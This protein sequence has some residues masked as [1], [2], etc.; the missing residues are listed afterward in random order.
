MLA[1][2]AATPGTLPL[3]VPAYQTSPPSYVLKRS[4]CSRLPPSAAIG[5]PLASAFA[6]VV[7]SGSTP[8]S[9]WNPPRW[10]RKPVMTSSKISSGAVAV[11]QRAQ[12]L[13]EARP[14]SDARG[15]VDDRLGDHR[16]HLTRLVREGAARRSRGR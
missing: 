3:Y 8:E 9:A 14:G 10:W 5:K 2:A 4:M 7:R 1:K 12:T 13:E 6:S 16:G 11:A 15:V